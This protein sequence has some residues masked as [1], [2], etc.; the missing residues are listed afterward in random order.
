MYSDFLYGLIRMGDLY[1]F[2][3]PIYSCSSWF[4]PLHLHMPSYISVTSFGGIYIDHSVQ[5]WSAGP[6]SWK[7]NMA[8]MRSQLWL[9]RSFFRSESCSHNSA[10][11]WM[12]GCSVSVHWTWEQPNRQFSAQQ[13]KNLLY[14]CYRESQFFLPQLKPE[15]IPPSSP[16]TDHLISMAVSLVVFLFF[17]FY[18]YFD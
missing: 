8:W 17:F 11:N 18:V 16:K 9:W 3:S 4:H 6:A 14:L 13:G 12:G 5:S 1:V 2:V 15:I 7:I 10:Q